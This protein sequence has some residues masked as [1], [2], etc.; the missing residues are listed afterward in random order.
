V[1]AALPD[2]GLRRERNTR[3]CRR[4]SLFFVSCG[5]LA[6]LA[7]SHAPRLRAQDVEAGR[8]LYDKWCVE[9]HG[10]KGEGDGPA[11][12]HML[13]RPR[14]FMQARYQIRTTESG[15]LPTDADLLAVL[16]N[17]MPGTAMPAWTNL[18]E[19]ERHDLIG[20]LKSFS[21]FFEDE[22]P[23]PVD[24]GADPGGGPE[25]IAS[26]AKVYETLECFKCHGPEGRG[27]GHSAPTL[28]DWRKLPIRAADLSQPWRFNGGASV[29]AIHTRVLT[30]LDGTPMPSAA[31]VLEAGIVSEADLWDLAHYVRSLAPEEPPRAAEVVVAR[32]QEGGLP[33]GTSDSAWSGVAS[34]YLPLVGQ[35]IQRPRQF[36]PTVNGVWVQ[37]VHDGSKLVVR[38]SWDDPS[39]SPDPD[40]D[41]WQRRLAGALFA[42]DARIPLTPLPDVLALQFPSAPPEGADLPYFLMG[43]RSDP[44][45]L[46]RWE[47]GHGVS[48]ARAT[49][50][51]EMRKLSDGGLRG[52]AAYR[53]GRRMVVFRRALVTDVKGRLNFTPGEAIPIAV[54]AWDGS[55]GETGRRGA[56]SAWA[57]LIL[58]EPASRMVLAG[59]VLVFLITFGFGGLAVGRA[60]R[61][62]RTDG[63][64]DSAI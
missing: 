10:E 30:G 54:F 46:W 56:V 25:A 31:D 50:L 3:R 61:R 49:G 20:Y 55:S 28:K 4:T 47:R 60:Q 23:E 2:P 16:E 5:L 40:W 38:V 19:A 51:G 35:V 48:E 17:G 43:D 39:D 44:V 11:A 52:E 15:A 8:A 7:A 1:S 41:E 21:P 53:E 12:S 59:P 58:E 22:V 24:F 18:S 57:T 62:A 33:Q 13:P 36:S 45:Y 26:G 27:N 9:C 32:L 63:G 34:A 37:A 64:Q 42:D 29:A 14:D 6:G